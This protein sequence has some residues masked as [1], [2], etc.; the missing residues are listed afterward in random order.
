MLDCTIHLTL[1][2]F[3]SESIFV[4]SVLKSRFPWYWT[5]SASVLAQSP[6]IFTVTDLWWM[7]EMSLAEFLHWQHSKFCYLRD[8]GEINILVKDCIRLLMWWAID[9]QHGRKGTEE[10]AVPSLLPFG[11]NNLKSSACIFP[12]SLS[13]VHDIFIQD[14]C[15]LVSIFVNVIVFFLLMDKFLSLPFCICVSLFIN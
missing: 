13:G 15:H 8:F 7:S 1:K 6:E 14:G 12:Q 4:L 11:M 10:G 9:S 3:R 5:Q 2:N